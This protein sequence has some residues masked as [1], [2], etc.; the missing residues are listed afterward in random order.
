MDSELPAPVLFT[1]FKVHKDIQHTF[2]RTS[3][4][5]WRIAP[6]VA[7]ALPGTDFR[8]QIA[9][10][11]SHDVEAFAAIFDPNPATNNGQWVTV[12]VRDDTQRQRYYEFEVYVDG[13]FVEANSAPGIIID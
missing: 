1:V 12:H 6:P 2:G 8:I 5:Q 3:V 13:Q 10:P 4:D 11:E 7:H 9:D